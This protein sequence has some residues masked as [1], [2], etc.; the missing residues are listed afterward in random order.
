MSLNASYTPKQFN[1]SGLHRHLGQD[2]RDAL[3][4]LRR[5][6]QG[7]EPTLRPDRGVPE[8]RPGGS[9][10]DA[11]VL[12]ADPAA[13]LRVQ[14]HGPARVLLREHDPRGPGDPAAGRRSSKP[15]SGASG[16]TR[17]GRPTSS[18]SARCAASAGRSATRIPPRG[19]C[20]ITGSPSTRWATWPGSCRCSSW[21][22]GSTPSSSTTRRPTA[23]EYIEA[24]FAN[25]A[26]DVAERRLLASAPTPAA[27]A[28]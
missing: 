8:G 13:R 12:R 10:G 3:Q 25:I 24:F 23:R 6:R 20:R 27:V 7:D 15:P 1:L 22:C 14:R 2:P 28:G 11:R 4:A 26:W 19:G 17:S 18:A 16:A 21:T 9:G 5:L